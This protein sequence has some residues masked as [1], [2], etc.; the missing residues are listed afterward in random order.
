MNRISSTAIFGTAEEKLFKARTQLALNHPFFM[1]IAFSLDYIEVTDEY[2]KKYFSGSNWCNTCAVDGVRLYWYRPFIDKLDVSEVA[3]VLCHE[4]LHVAWLHM[5]RRGHRHPVLW[6]IAGDHIINNM[7]KEAKF[8]LPLPHVCDPKYANWSIYAVYEDLLKD[9]PK[10]TISLPGEDDEGKDDGLWGAVIDITDGEGKPLTESEKSQIEAEVKVMVQQAAAAAKAR[11]KL[12]GSLEG[13]L[14]A[15]GKPKINWKDYIQNWVKGH[16]PDDYTWSRPNRKWMA[17]N[18]TYMPRMKLS[19]AGR[20]VLFIDTSGSVS[21]VE[22]VEY[23]TEIT[24]VI[25]LLKPDS[26]TIIQ[27]DARIQRIDEW[28]FGDDFGKLHV[29]GRGGTCVQPGFQWL[30][31]QEE[32]PDWIIWFTDGEIGDYPSMAPDIPILWCVTGRDTAPFGTYI[33]LREAF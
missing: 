17:V 4:I 25:D 18:G 21:D 8:K 2:A 3:A 19:G 23:I 9:I 22:L 13:L 7:L 20:G 16:I 5:T 10:V 12:P 1:R 27:H 30:E 11:G 24:G 29:K 31:T 33:D 32:R 28:N 6:N 15:A 26:L 14:E